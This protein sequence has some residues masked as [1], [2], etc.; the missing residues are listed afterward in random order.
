MLP[1]RDED[2]GNVPFCRVPCNLGGGECTC[3][4]RHSEFSRGALRLAALGC[5]SGDRW[6][7]GFYLHGPYPG[8]R[9][10]SRKLS[11]MWILSSP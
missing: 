2:L 9:R 7:G 6:L 5:G 4:Q 8:L 3:A 1:G 11:S 10:S